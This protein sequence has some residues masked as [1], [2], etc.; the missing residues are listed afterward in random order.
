[1]EENLKLTDWLMVMMNVSFYGFPAHYYR[2]KYPYKGSKELSSTI[3]STLQAGGIK[4]K[5]VSRAIDHG[6]WVCFKVGKQ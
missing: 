4:V 1:M 3:A 2:E 5:L 6:V